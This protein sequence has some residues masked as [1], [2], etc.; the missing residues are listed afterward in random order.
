MLDGFNYAKARNEGIE[1]TTNYQAGKNFKA[2]G[3]IAFANQQATDLVSNQFLFTAD[4]VAFI[5]NHYIYTDHNQTITASAGLT[6]LWQ[7]TRFSYRYDLRQRTAQRG[8]QL[9]P[10]PCL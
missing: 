7:G 6:Y 5:A 4:D 9:G 3:N 2:Y 8:I 10:R 1:V